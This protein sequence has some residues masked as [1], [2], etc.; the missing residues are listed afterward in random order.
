MGARGQDQVPRGRGR[1]HRKGAGG[2]HRPAAGQE[3]RQAPGA[4]RQGVGA[5]LAK[6][7]KMRILIGCYWSMICSDL[8][9]PAEASTQTT[10]GAKGFAQAGN[11]FAIFGIML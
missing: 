11:R 3:L 4:R 5:G 10:N 7:A 9:S 2:L 6:A 8:P 1:G